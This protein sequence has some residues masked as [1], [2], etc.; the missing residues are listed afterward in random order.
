MKE[1]LRWG[2][3]GTGGIASNFLE[4]LQASRRC[5][6]VNVVGSSAE[7]AR[8]FAARWQLP[9]AS[10]TLGELLADRDVDAVYVATP[11]PL[12]EA[13]AL[14]AIAAGKAVLCEKPFTMNAPSAARVLAAAREKGVFVMEAFMYRCHPVTRELVRRL[15]EGS[16]GKLLHVRA[17]FGFRKPRDPDSRLYNLALGGGAIL[18]V[19]CYTASFSRLVAGVAAGLPFAEPTAMQASGLLGPTGSDELASALLTFASGFTAQMT[20]AVHHDV[21]RITT[22]FGEEGRLVVADPWAPGSQRMGRE[23]SFTIFRDGRDPE[24]VPV[25]AALATY[26]LE[27]ELVADS[28]PATE[29]A[30][31]AVGWDDTL[32]NMRLLDAWSAALR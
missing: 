25:G 31:P 13:Q 19:G 3:I 6:V 21:G 27:A 28:L 4:A 1:Q 16:I 8:A 30:W 22:V 12:H 5:R 17:D 15:Q 24:V 32:G 18:D 26:G 2:V 29:A 11:H 7:K 20:C 9:A 23:S 14:E 10:A